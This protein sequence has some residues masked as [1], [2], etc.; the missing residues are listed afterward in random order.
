M[1]SLEIGYTVPNGKCVCR[2]FQ[3]KTLV[4]PSF[5]VV[6]GILGETCKSL[7]EDAQVCFVNIKTTPLH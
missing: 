7:G 4:L 2:T 1:Y 6:P 3:M 5:E